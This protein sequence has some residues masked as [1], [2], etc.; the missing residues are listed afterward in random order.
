MSARLLRRLIREILMNEIDI[1]DVQDFCYTAGS[2]HVMQTCNISGNKYF[3]KFSDE[4]LFDGVDPS[5]QILIEYLAYRIYGLYS[6]VQIPS[7]EL[8]YDASNKRVGIA[9]TP[10][11][12]KP[13]LGRVD[14]KFLAKMMSQG[15]Y[16]DVFLANWDVVG[17]GSGNVFSDDE[18]ATRIDPGGSLTFRA[19]GGRKGKAFGDKP[20]ELETMLK[21]GSGTGNV[22]QYADLKVAAKEFLSV[23]WPK[24]ASEIDAVGN[25]VSEQL[26]QRDMSDLLSQWESDV[27][28]IKSTLA[29]RHNEVKSHAKYILES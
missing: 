20:G 17:T 13:A 9:T 19:Q 26:Q 7:P 16:I 6:G 5:L 24:I 27:N 25:E 23:D 15:V 12:G 18:S 8:V 21:K 1:S 3:L 14:P 10:A 2:T 29:K 11:R 28:L 4:G 22:Y